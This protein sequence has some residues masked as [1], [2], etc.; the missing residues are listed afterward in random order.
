MNQK[1]EEMQILSLNS[2]VIVM[3]L[4]DG[5]KIILLMGRRGSMNFKGLWRKSKLMIIQL[6]MKLWMFQ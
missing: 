5:G 1:Y 4:L 6:K 2:V 3:K